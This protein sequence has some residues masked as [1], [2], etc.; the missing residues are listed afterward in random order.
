MEHWLSD[1]IESIAVT[2]SVLAFVLFAYDKISAVF[3][4][5]RISESMLL[6]TSVCFG[7]A[8]GLFGMILFNHKTR[9]PLFF[10]GIPVL[11]AAQIAAYAYIIFCGLR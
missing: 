1:N 6:I 9:K 2:M 4:K 11:L 3:G 10:I 5:G 8:G 7:A